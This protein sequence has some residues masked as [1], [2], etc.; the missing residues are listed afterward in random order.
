MDLIGSHLSNYFTHPGVV[1][2]IED[3]SHKDDLSKPSSSKDTHLS[4]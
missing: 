4:G 3:I 1:F 2:R